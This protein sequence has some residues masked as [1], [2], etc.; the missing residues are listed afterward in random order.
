MTPRRDHGDGLLPVPGDG[1]YEWNGFWDGT[2]L[3]WSKNPKA[4]FITTSN[5]MNLPA[6]YPVAQRKLGFEW[7]NEARHARITQVLSQPPKVTLEDS[8]NCRTIRSRCPRNAWPHC[9]DRCVR[10]T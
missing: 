8:Q 4:G 5:E 9:C 1:H 10:R 2:V 7:A 6:G 3:P